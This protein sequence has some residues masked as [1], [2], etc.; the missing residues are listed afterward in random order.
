VWSQY[1]VLS[2]YNLLASVLEIADYF[3]VPDF[4][5]LDNGFGEDSN[6][7]FFKV[8]A[9]A[10]DGS[11]CESSLSDIGDGLRVLYFPVF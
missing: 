9:M 8:G 6:L 11:W 7:M 1:E 10:M 2:H 4:C 3:N 5:V